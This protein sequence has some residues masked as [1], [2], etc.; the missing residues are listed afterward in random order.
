M[1]KVYELV[2]DYQPSGDQPG[3]INQL[4][5]GLDAGLAHQTLLGV[6]GSGKTFTLANVIA[7]AQRPA[8]LL[9][10]N[11]TLAAQ[12]YGEMKSFF[13]NN[14]VEYFVSYY[15][16]YQPEAYVP[17]TDTF[18]EKD[19][20]VNAHI[21]Q[22]RLSATKAL[23]ERKD[24]IIVASVSAIYGLGDPE[25]Y[26]QMMLHL[27][28]GDVIDQRDML[29]RLAELQYSRN[30]V[31]FERGQFRV[32]GEVIDIFPA[33]SDQ[34]AV[35]VEMFDDE[36]DCISVFDPLT[37]VVKQRDLPRYTIYPKTHYVTPRDRIL[38]AIENIKVE[39]EVR[40]KQLLDNN[41]LLE[42]QRISQR[43]QFD[44]EMMNELGFCSGI[45][46]YS[47]YLSGRSE[48]EPPPTLFDYLPHD[49]LLIIDE[50]HVTVPQI[51]AMYKGDRSRKE[52][53]VEFGFR[54]PSALDNRPLKFEE[55]EALA[56]QTIFVSATPGNYELEKSAGDVADQVVRPTGLLDPELEVRP[57]ATQVDDLLSEIRIRAAKDER[58]LVTTLTKRMAED[59]TEYLHE[60]DVKVR[61]LHSDI[62]T[63]ERVEIIRDLRLG[64]FDVLVG[65]NLLREG[66]DMPEVSLV[67][68]LDADKEG[69]LRSERS[70]IQT[71]GR[72]ARNIE[73]KAILYAD[74]ITNSMKKAMDETNRRREKQEAYNEEMGISPQALKRN[75]KDIMELGD[76]T[77][78]KRQRNTK[79]VPLSK[80]AEPSQT[81]EALSPQQLEKEIS[82]LEAAMYQ[83][84][85]D[86]EFELAAQK[87]DEIEKLRAQFI[88]NS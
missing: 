48:G 88:A 68:I 67:A 52:T 60:H 76:I 31:A 58:V 82:R 8:I 25:S 84:A 80:V 75:I 47:R 27:R 83:H 16:Y 10:P 33:E 14:A 4:L 22:M 77:K 69:F 21:E 39:L 46:N 78:S 87:R 23:L 35:R 38:E 7:Q 3:A 37:G 17:T 65:I 61:Y 59:L 2:S 56:P 71:I 49:G 43:T 13:P 73:G 79:Q 64:E 74:R 54:L 66:L 30:D 42:E 40:K 20:S 55:F 32:R 86:L 28:R 26:L 72:A 19:A 24:A 1:S 44:I 85:Q 63:V 11:K 6:T 29:R 81:Y 15:D 57:V 50:S 70:L 62:D 53:L 51:G 9:A 5:E 12:L 18:I 41:K 36:V 45:E 34:D